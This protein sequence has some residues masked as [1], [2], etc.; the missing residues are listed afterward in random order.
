MPADRPI[1]CFGE[2]LLRLSAPAGIGLSHTDAL[3][4]S[5]GGAE[6]N[7]AAALSA[8]GHGTRMV[9]VLPDHAIARR[10]RAE[11]AVAGVDARYLTERAGRMGL[12][13]ADPPSGPM[14]G[15]VIYDRAD[16]AF[17]K[18]DP[19]ELALKDALRDA[20]LLHLSGIT[21]ALGPHGIALAKAAMAAAQVAGV[22]VCFD[23]NY[24]AKLWESWD[25][26]PQA[27][28]RDCLASAAILIGNHRDIGL[29]LGQTF[30]G[31]EEER[32]A[33]AAD[34]AFAAFPDLQLIASTNR[35]VETT[36]RHR[37]SARVATRD[38][39]FRTPRIVV[40]PVVDRIGTGDA[41]AAGVL[42][43]WAEDGSVRQMAE[44]G[45]AL[46]AMK[47]GVPGD[48]IQVSRADLEAFD[49][50]ASDFNR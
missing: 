10:A 22:P 33:A 11:L 1:V 8:L 37:L 18:V 23:G 14:P 42:L 31:T 27:T 38:D 24:R 28:L 6:F 48:T 41:F 30:A 45:L 7:V 36:A 15:W 21:P 16:S 29:V 20:R 4:V 47:H 44:A 13:F 50:V 46:M 43:Y 2:I 25:S 12:Y 40:D 49:P 26:N 39:S 3:S 9:S 5:V 35:T 19:A 32:E 34:A 17:A